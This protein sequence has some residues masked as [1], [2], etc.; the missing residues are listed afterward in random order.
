MT[1]NDETKGHM[2]L[3]LLYCMN[4]TNEAKTED[5]QAMRYC[6]SKNSARNLSNSC[7]ISRIQI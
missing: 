6:I 7:L 1:E 5:G 3:I 2:S 4:S